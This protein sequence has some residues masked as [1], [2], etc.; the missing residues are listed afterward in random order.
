VNQA[1]LSIARIDESHAKAQVSPRQVRLTAQG[2]A[3][4]LQRWFG[5]PFGAKQVSEQDLSLRAIGVARHGTQQL[6]FGLLQVAGARQRDGVI[7]AGRVVFGAKSKGDVEMVFGLG[8]VTVNR[9]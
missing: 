1:L 8:E 2:L 9:Q 6:L 5:L 4:M 7:V 3:I